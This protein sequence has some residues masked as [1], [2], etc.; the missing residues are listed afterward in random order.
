MFCQSTEWE[1]GV[2]KGGRSE[3]GDRGRDLNSHDNLSTGDWSYNH[4]L[5]LEIPP[6]GT[7]TL[8]LSTCWLYCHNTGCIVEMSQGGMDG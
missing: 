2:R 7:R 8:Q 1:G 3:I 5:A 4:R 6:L